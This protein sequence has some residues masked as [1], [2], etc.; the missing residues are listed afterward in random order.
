MAPVLRSTI[1]IHGVISLLGATALLLWVGQQH[2]MSFLFGA[3]LMGLNWWLLIQT[4][5]RIL[6][7]KSI[8]LA[9]SIIVIKWT[10]FGT[11]CIVL[12]RMSWI[13]PSWLV[14]GIGSVMVSALIAA[15]WGSKRL[16]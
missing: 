11:L 10:L 2:A 1:V 15:S 4:W 7:K 13:V 6:G 14:L 3:A 9:V 16:K 5:E 12:A 8:A